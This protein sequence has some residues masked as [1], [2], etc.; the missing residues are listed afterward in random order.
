[1]VNRP[2]YADARVS[3]YQR[4]GAMRSDDNG[5]RGP[6]YEPNIFGGPVENPALMEAAYGFELRGFA[7]RFDKEY[8]GNDDFTQPGNLFRLMK[9][10]DK[11]RL[12]GNI[13]AHMRPVDREIQRRQIRHFYKADPAYWGGR[14]CRTRNRN[15]RYQKRRR[16][17]ALNVRLMEYVLA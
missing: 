12:I 6:N 10:D 5:G 11:E 16:G 13:V 17:N 4:D 2:R 14:R 3:N 7:E 8:P 9:P 1:M 15:G